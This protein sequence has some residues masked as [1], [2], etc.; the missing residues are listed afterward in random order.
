[1][2]KKSNSNSKKKASP[3]SAARI[4]VAKTYKLFIGGGF[5]RSERGRYLQLKDKEGKLVANYAWATRK[6]F[7]NALVVAR[8]AQAGWAKRS[9]FNRS[10][11]MYRM[12]EMLESRREV[13]ERCLT[14]HAGFSAKDASEEV[15]AT[16]DRIFWYAG[17]AD[18][19]AQVL[20]SVNPVASSFFNFTFPEPTGVVTVFSSMHSPLLGLVSAF[21]PVI[22]SGNSC[23]LIVENDAPT[24]AI[25]LAEVLATS[26]LPGGVVNILT[27]KRDELISHIAGHM[28]LNAIACYGGPEEQIAD[29]QKLSAENV[30]RVSIFD[31]PPAKDWKS[32]DMQSL[33]ALTPYIEWKT[34]WHP[35]GT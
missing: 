18:K 22:V 2:T 19:Y 11:I 7:R 5:P 20:G 25:E 12:A 27:G 33:Y 4:S 31:D 29:I 23:I 30:K 10:Q 26:D 9:A 32:E 3:T 13:F 6:D 28:D 1:M 21:A 24:I 17:W 14:Q 8:K 35:V 16:I 34:A 15:D